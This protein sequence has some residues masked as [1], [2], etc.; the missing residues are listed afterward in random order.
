MKKTDSIVRAIDENGDWMFGFGRQCYKKEVAM[1]AQRI[2]THIRSW[3]FNCFFDLE[4]GIDWYNYLGNR[5]TER[6]IQ[7]ACRREIVKIKE[8]TS[9]EDLSIS[10][11]DERRVT[12]YYAVTTQYGAIDNEEVISL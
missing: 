7:S 1:V 12:L 5:R 4:A 8:I 2:V 11:D 6:L 10:V 3:Y 9:I